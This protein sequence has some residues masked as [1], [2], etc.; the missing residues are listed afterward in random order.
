MD[1]I[2][3]VLAVA[4]APGIL[5]RFYHEGKGSDPIVH[6]YETFLARYDP[7]E[8]ER[9]G[10]YYTPEPVVG[11]I[12]RSLHALLQSELGQRDGLASE[13]VTLLD[14]AA[15]TMTFIARAAA[16][17]V[18]EFEAKYGKGGRGEFIRRH[19]LKNFYAFALMMAPYAVGHLKMS[20]FLEELGHRLEDDERV[21]F[22]LTNTL[23]NEELEQSR[24]PGFSA[25]AEESRLAGEVKKRSPVLVILGNPPYSGHST[26]TGAWIRGLIEAYRQV[27]GK[28]LGERNPKWLQDDYVKFLRFAQWKIDKAGRGLVGMITN[29]GY[30]D[31]A[32]FRGM[33]QSLMQ[34]FDEIYILDLH[35]NSLK[36]ESCPDGSPDK[37]VFDI[38]QGV[39]IAF[40]VKRGGGHKRDAV[41]RHHDLFGQR[42]DKY[43]W[44]DSHDIADT[45]W[46]KL[47]PRSGGYLFIRRDET[48]M[49]CYERFLPLP[50][51]FPVNSVGIVTARDALTVHWSAREVWNTVNTFAKMEPELARKGYGLGKD[52][53]DWQVALAQQDINDSGPS[54]ENLAPILYRPFDIRHTYY[55]GKTKGFI[56]MPRKEVMQHMLAGDKLAL[57]TPKQHKDEFGAFATTA[58]GLHKAVAAYDI[59]YFFPLYLYTE[60][61]KAKKIKSVKTSFMTMMLFEPK[62]FYGVKKPNLSPAVTEMLAAAFGKA[63]AP[64]EVFNYIY[65]VLHAP[66][67]RT[68]YAEF[69][70]ADFPRVPFTKDLKLFGRLA[71][72]GARLTALHLL[73]S[74]ELDPPACR[75]EGEGDGRVSKDNANGLRYAAGEGRVYINAAQHFAPVPEAVWAYRVGGYQVCE[76]WLKD[77]KERRLELA[78]I[79][80]YCRIVTALGRTIGLQGEID[81]LYPATEAPNR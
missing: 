71:A 17:A 51:I 5:D 68:K 37:N 1:D 10:V 27:D 70:K 61:K 36:K 44:L 3:E 34:T 21:P 47:A 45:R 18:A 4:D 52:A 30:L 11:Y 50:E 2:A 31:N 65:A 35:G 73:K 46:R 64:E 7:A 58:I 6:F 33:R 76:K 25:L 77:R 75:F 40:F 49:R 15:G 67:Y 29:N 66:S 81:A 63:P 72:L 13:G 38:R 55:T 57:I 19:I 12:V 43:A 60:I 16:L 56:C 39:A 9:R 53:R 42:E 78:E 23:D 24:L 79:Q 80:T 59:N 14:P 48:A 32:T 8:R 26:N 28:P 74:P 54:R 69:L 62:E 20:F 22:Y 41:V